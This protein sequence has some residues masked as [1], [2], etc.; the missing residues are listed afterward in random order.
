MADAAYALTRRKGRW[1]TIVQLGATTLDEET[2]EK[3][4]NTTIRNVRLGVKEQT[5]Y[6]R[7]LKA[8]AA[9]QDI[10]STC[11]IFWRPDVRDLP[12]RFPVEAYIVQ[13]GIKY[14]VVSTVIEDTSYVITAH[15]VVG[16]HGKAE[17][18]A[19]IDQALSVQ[20]TVVED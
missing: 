2:G 20:N 3:K 14:Q 5:T 10:G 15:E 4:L 13:D 9:A 8:R 18:V 7:I 17:M 6:G 11:F 1:T 12:A 16:Q 19:A